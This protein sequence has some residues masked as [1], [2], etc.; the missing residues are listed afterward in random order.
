MAI[1]GM[2]RP[3]IITPEKVLN[4][5]SEYDVFR[6]Y[7]PNTDWVPNVITFSPFFSTI[8]LSFINSSSDCSY[9]IQYMSVVNLTGNNFC[10][11][12]LIYFLV[13]EDI[14]DNNILT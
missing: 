11:P 8:Y 6:Y 5:V 7:M 10:L 3:S 13:A 12:S 9:F 1:N 2:K 4:K 14:A